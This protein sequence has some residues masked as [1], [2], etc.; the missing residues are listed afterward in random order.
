MATKSYFRYWD[1]LVENSDGKPILIVEVK[2]KTNTSSEWASKLRRNILAHD[3]LPKTPYF[4]I[5]FPDKFYLWTDSKVGQNDREVKAGEPNYIVDAFPILKP[6]L[7]K[8]EVTVDHLTGQSLELIVASWLGGLIHSDQP[9]EDLDKS[10]SWLID[11]GLYADLVGGKIE[12]EA[13]A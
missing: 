6:Y 3:S 10:Q 9:S 8:A 12:Y 13:V 1:L 2:G 5:V 7:T 11:S 4:L